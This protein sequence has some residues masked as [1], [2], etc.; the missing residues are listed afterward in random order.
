MRPYATI[1][2]GAVLVLLSVGIVI[3]ASTGS[4]RGEALFADAHYF[5]TR[6]LIWLLVAVVAAAVLMRVD[7]HRWQALAFPA[8]GAGALLLALVLVPGIGVEINSS[9][10]WLRFGPLSLQPSELAKFATVAALAAWMSAAGRKARE[11]KT[12]LV[13]P[14]A[15][16]GLVLVLILLAPDYGT[17]LLLALAGFAVMWAGGTRLS[18]LTVTG[19]LGL[20]LFLLAVA[21]DPV[22][23]G[24]MLA[25][26]H[27]ESHPAIAH[28]LAQSKIAF[29]HGGTWGVGLGN[30]MQKQFYLPEAHTDFIFAII[31]EELGFAA[32]ILVVALFATILVCGLTISARAADSFG[33]L[34]AFG[35]TMLI[36]LQAF[37]NIGVVT[38]CLP[39]TGIPL[40]FMSY[41]GTSLVVSMACV[42]VL[43]NVAYH[44][45]AAY[46]DRHTRVIKDRLHRI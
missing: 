46:R 40:P 15:G 29:I 6:Q 35:M 4:V 32:T 5:V 1:L 2:I 27:P 25:F 42:A 34:L 19:V 44:D 8:W 37:M 39:T 22:R 16:L 7:Y 41:G 18:Y 14:L 10:R 11:F 33:K 31:G 12:G 36:V 38:G 26:M 24:R 13:V 9:Y 28:H 21:H 45:D 20:G 3:L 43:L 17:M 30:S 23:A